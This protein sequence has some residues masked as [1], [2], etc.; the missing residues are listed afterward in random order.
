[1]TYLDSV[2]ADIRNAV[3]ADALPEG[4][5]TGLFRSYA[6][7]LL[8]KGGAVTGEDVHNAW[9]AWMASKGEDHESM[10][11]FNQLPTETQAEDSPFVEA[12]RSVARSSE[13][14]TQPGQ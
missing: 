7:L 14:Q 9:V 13:E 3:Q 2:A 1:M 12:I 5:T 10:V 8:A 4:D 11:P 6:V